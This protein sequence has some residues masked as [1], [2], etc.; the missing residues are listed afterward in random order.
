M[1]ITRNMIERTLSAQRI[2]LRQRAKMHL[3]REERWTATSHAYEQETSDPSPEEETILNRLI[4]ISNKMKDQHEMLEHRA[5]LI[6]TAIQAL[7]SEEN[8]AAP[9]RRVAR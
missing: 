4:V 5:Y 3:K 1:K 7:E 8:I 6:D 2:I 9:L